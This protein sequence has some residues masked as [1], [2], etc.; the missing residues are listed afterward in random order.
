MFGRKGNSVEELKKRAAELGPKAAKGAVKKVGKISKGVA[1][2][3]ERIPGE[4][5]SDLLKI[6][7]LRK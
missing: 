3:L 7:T 1:K 4:V 5:L 2:E 6:V